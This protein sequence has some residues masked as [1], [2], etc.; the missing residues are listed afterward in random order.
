MKAIPSI[1]KYMT[2]APQT[3]GDD[4]TLASAQRIMK[5][6]EVR[7]LPVLHGGE[8]VG[9]VT[10]RD[11]AVASALVGASPKEMKLS[12]IAGGEVYT[13]SPDAPLDE[14]ASTM[15]RNKYGSAVIVHNGKPVGIFTTVDACRALAEVFETRLR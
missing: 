8:L 9:I 5:E 14:V 15:A 3:I 1:Q 10:D 2:V 12:D 7:H 11:L 6:L 4:Q 13:V